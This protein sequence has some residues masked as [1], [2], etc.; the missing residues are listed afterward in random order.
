M[1]EG[2]VTGG[3]VDS[4]ME[5]TPRSVGQASFGTSDTSSF[6]D[7]PR[8]E[9]ESPETPG[10]GLWNSPAIPQ[11]F[12][13]TA[14]REEVLVRR[15]LLFEQ[16]KRAND[17]HNDDDRMKDLHSLQEKGLDEKEK[18]SDFA[19]SSGGEECPEEMFDILN[20]DGARLEKNSLS[21]L[22][23]SLEAL[24]TSMMSPSKSLPSSLASH[25]QVIRRHFATPLPELLQGS[26][27]LPRL[28][29]FFCE[30]LLDRAYSEPELFKQ[31]ASPELVEIYHAEFNAGVIRSDVDSV[32]VGILL[33]R[34]LRQLPQSLV[35]QV[36]FDEALA[37]VS[38]RLKHAER[39]LRIH[40]AIIALENANIPVW[41]VLDNNRSSGLNVT[42]PDPAMALIRDY[43]LSVRAPT[44]EVEEL[45]FK[46]PRPHR[47]ALEY[48]CVFTAKM[49]LN[50]SRNRFSLTEAAS[51]FAPHILRPTTW[52]AGPDVNR[53][54]W[55][56]KHVFIFLVL[57]AKKKHHV[58]TR[59]ELREL[60]YTE[61]EM[62]RYLVSR[63][64]PV[65][66]SLAPT[67]KQSA[68]ASTI[69]TTGSSGGGVLQ[70]A[71]SFSRKDQQPQQP[72]GDEEEEEMHDIFG[73]PHA[74]QD[75]DLGAMDAITL[76][77][78]PPPRNHDCSTTTTTTE[79]Y[80][81][82][83]STAPK[84]TPR[85]LRHS[86]A[87]RAFS[88]MESEEERQQS[89]VH[90]FRSLATA[91][92]ASEDCSEYLEECQA[93]FEW[94]DEPLVM[95]EQFLGSRTVHSSYSHVEVPDDDA[96]DAA[97]P[98]MR[99]LLSLAQKRSARVMTPLGTPN[100]R[101]VGSNSDGDAE[102]SDFAANYGGH[103]AFP[104]NVIYERHGPVKVDNANSGTTSGKAPYRYD[105]YSDWLNDELPAMHSG[106]SCEI[107][108]KRFATFF[109][110]RMQYGNCHYCGRL[111]CKK[112]LTDSSLVPAFA[113]V[114]ND[115]RQKPLCA[116]CGRH[117]QRHNSAPVVLFDKV[118]DSPKEMLD[119]IWMATLYKC[120]GFLQSFYFQILVDCPSQGY[121]ESLLSSHQRAFLEP[122]SRMSLQD[123]KAV[124]SGSY[125]NALEMIITLAE[126]HKISC[127]LCM[128]QILTCASGRDFCHKRAYE[129]LNVRGVAGNL[130]LCRICLKMAHL[131]CTQKQE[132]GGYT[133]LHCLHCAAS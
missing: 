8:D 121:F 93:L 86:S 59:D 94:I 55:L 3:V 98:P 75:I 99:G 95:P 46:L 15:A 69:G 127:K 115:F 131:S 107:C 39:A 63:Y 16:Q 130:R 73:V 31:Q 65:I 72:K 29:V 13:S 38:T 21:S 43:A 56:Q 9:L 84:G 24:S 129:P 133:C 34:F 68:A 81:P 89:A 83:R 101:S 23:S 109:G 87:S 12:Q 102:Y 67:P 82:L 96:W 4:P 106:D 7:T 80:S 126:A 17:V 42:S 92:A 90:Q 76:S 124:R 14:Q 40:P 11:R 27:R 18:P 66:A 58:L 91:T 36:F 78:S 119:A 103:I 128:N 123:L 41:S 108:S 47:D 50:E 26:V 33:K 45:F 44:W 85:K 125:A 1:H 5:G 62:V 88:W 116:D 57:F 2:W 104:S 105:V 54:R 112:C 52:L 114:S 61:D 64:F 132:T 48:F 22:A 20:F 79:S 30:F 60:D 111:L 28:L 70:S 118:L 117:L 35:P 51:I 97:V 71:R 25:T 37:I 77:F 122:C 74:F 113:F 110:I 100:R 19:L 49:N 6:Y 32:V 120:R 53:R 10:D